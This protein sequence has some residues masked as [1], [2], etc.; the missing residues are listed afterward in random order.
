M[1]RNEFFKKLGI[2]I[3]VAVVAP[4]VLAEETPEIKDQEHSVPVSTC[5]ENEYILKYEGRSCH[6][7]QLGWINDFVIIAPKS[8]LE[9]V[10]CFTKEQFAEM[11]KEY[12]Y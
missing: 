10:C 8:D 6:V 12:V 9:Q 3:G 11:T 1:N 4:K 7:V 5:K 2:G